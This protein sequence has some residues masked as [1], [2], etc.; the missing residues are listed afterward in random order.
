MLGNCFRLI[1]HAKYLKDKQ[2]NFLCIKILQLLRE[3]IPLDDEVI[4][5]NNSCACKPVFLFF[6]YIEFN[7]YILSHCFHLYLLN[8][9]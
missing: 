8:S 5:L 1:N 2:D 3:M 6:L 7:S 9:Y 4:I